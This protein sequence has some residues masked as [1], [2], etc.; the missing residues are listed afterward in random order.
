MVDVYRRTTHQSNTSNVLLSP[1]S[2]TAAF[3]VLS[4]G[5][6]ADTSA[7]ILRGININLSDAYMNVILT[8][9]RELNLLSESENYQLPLVT[10]TSLFIDRSVKLRSGFATDIQ[11]TYH[12]HILPITFRDSTRAKDQINK[13]VEKETQ[14]LIQDS[15]DDLP[16]G[17]ALV[18]VNYITFHGKWSG[19]LEGKRIVEED[20]HVDKDTTVRVPMLNLLGI[21]DLHRDQNL[22]C[23]VVLEHMKGGATAFFFLPDPGKLQQLEETLT[24]Q[25]VNDILKT[26][27]V[28]SV[29]LQFPK[30]SISATYDL[31]EVL[32]DMNITKIF[33]NGA[34]L[35]GITK[36][37]PL[38]LSK[39]V[40]RAVL[41]IDEKGTEAAGSPSLEDSHWATHHTIR[42]NRPFLIVI[43]EE[44]SDF[45]LFIAKVL[46]PML[47]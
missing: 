25:H 21:F 30:L 5:A 23:W 28:R 43:K 39:A 33:S 10:G 26:S 42:F 24:F 9:Y 34:H 4:L 31:K 44:F 14:G 32:N 41:T 38:K 22:S 27:T 29:N 1:M 15:V 6:E 36:H 45:I 2:I 7:Q 19:T 18:L 35:S 37:A 20:F 3:V 16:E 8:C 17:T 40:H 11:N 13:H 12:T 46:N 47:R